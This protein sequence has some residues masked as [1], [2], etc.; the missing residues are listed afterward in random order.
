[1]WSIENLR[2]LLEPA[3]G[4]KIRSDTQFS[5]R[6]PVHDDAHASLSVTWTDDGHG[7]KVLLHCHGCGASGKDLAGALGISLGDL[8]DVPLPSRPA[9]KRVGRSPLQRIGGQRRGR[10]G[11]LPKAIV[12]KSA[13]AEVEHTWEQVEVYPYTDA[14]G[15]LVQEVVREECTTC[16]FGRHKQFRQVFINALGRRVKQKPRGFARVLYRMQA[17]IAAVAAGQPIWL[18]EGEKD[19]A[20]AERLGLVATTNAQGGRAFPSECAELF[21][22]ATVRVVLDRDDAGWDRGVDLVSL[23]GGV[24]A[25]VDLLLPGT[26]VAKSD[27]TDHVEAGLWAHDDEFGGLIPV[28]ASEVAAHSIAGMARAKAVLVEKAAA[29]AQARAELADAQENDELEFKRA[30]RWAAEAEIRFEALRDVVDHTRRQAA[31]AGTEWAGTAADEAVAMWRLARSAA[32]LAHDVAKV[33]VPPSLQHEQS[34]EG[35]VVHAD[36]VHAD[37]DDADSG[38]GASPREQGHTGVFEA[39]T[40]A[41]VGEKQSRR[42][43]A[44]SAP[45]FRIVD[46][47]LVEITTNKD[48][49]EQAKLVLGIDARIVEMEYLEAHDDS[50]DVDAPKL[51]G[52]EG[53]LGQKEANPPAPEQLSAVIIGYTHPDSGEFMR[54]RI[55]AIDYRDCGWVESLPG[56]PAYDSKPSGVAKLR[57]AL[58]V[59]GGTITRTVRFRSTGWR[60]DAAGEWFFV[61][62]GGAINAE[63]ARNAP[64]L[65]S[66]PLARY[67]LPA[68]SQ[69]SGRLRHAF[70][71]D[72]AAML[73]TLPTRISSALLGHVYRSALGPNPWVLLLVG[74]PGSYKTSTASIGMHHWGE[75]WDR[76]RPAS[77]MSGN[78]DTLNAL[79]IKLHSAKDALYW[80]DDVAPTRD[81][82][83][84]QKSLEEFARMV[85]N[86]EQRSRSSRDGLSILDGTPP[87]AS[88]I[89]TSEVMPRP[90]SGAQRM[91]AVPL[92]KDEISLEVLTDLDRD[93]SRHGRALLMA[94]FLQYLAANLEQVRVDAFA[95]AA[96]YAKVLRDSGES[97]RQ[98]EAVGEVWGGWVAMTRF[99]LDAGAL[100]QDEVEQILQ[101]VRGGLTDALAAASDPDLPSR[102]GARVRELLAHALRTGLAY[103]DDVRTGQA[104]ES[105]LAG[106]L[107]W[108]RTNVGEYQGIA[109]W[110][111]DARGIRLGYVLSDPGPRDGG[112]AQ[113]LIESTAL[114]QVLKAVAGTMSDAPQIDRGTALRALYDEGILIAEE[115]AGKTPRYT[116]QRTIHCEGRRQR[117][118]SLRLWAVIGDDPDDGY[119]PAVTDDS[120]PDPTGPNDVDADRPAD[121]L[122]RL[123]HSAGRRDS[124]IQ[125][126]TLTE[127]VEEAE[128]VES[129]DA[130][131]HRATLETFM[132]AV[133]CLMCGTP[134]GVGYEGLPI[135]ITCWTRSTAATRSSAVAARANSQAPSIPSTPAEE[136]VQKPVPA[137]VPK[138]TEEPREQPTPGRASAEVQTTQPRKTA[139]TRASFTA[140]AAIV[141]VDGIWLPDGTRRDL[142]EEFSH[143]GHVA[144]LA[145]TLN[146]GTAV[147]D[148]WSEPGQVWITDALARRFGLDPDQL[149]D[150]PR[151]R[152]DEMRKLT[153]GLP[154]V[155]EALAQGWE[156]GGK[157][158]DALGTWTRV[159]RGERRGVWV[160]F[161]SAMSR[162]ELEM[163]VLAD[164]PS[165]A[166]L[167][168]RL[169]LF[170]SALRF[171][172]AMSAASTGF[173]L[174]SS[175]RAKDRKE[176]FAPSDPVPP[177]QMSNTETDL[178]W[179]RNPTEDESECR[180]VHAYDRGGSHAAG[181]AGLGLGI[182]DP[183]HHEQGRA[184]DA[185]L[186]GYWRIEIPEAGD[187]RYPNPLNPRG[188]AFSEPKWVTTPTLQLATEFG[189]SPEVLEAY[190]W[191]RHGRILD[192]WYAHIRD[193]RTAL[194]VDDVHSQVARDQLKVVYTRTLGMLGSSDFMK[195]RAGYAPER[196]HHIIAKARANILRRVNK[197]GQETDR[198]PLAI[199]NDTIVYASNEADP[200][201]AWPGAQ[202]TLGRGFGQYKWEGSSLLA[203]HLEFLTGKGYRGKDHLDLDWNRSGH[204]GGGED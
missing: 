190:V 94:S 144:E 24:G 121:L 96:A 129:S 104:P 41:P 130:E 36:V 65:L 112:E 142:P 187:W 99:L 167:A 47:Q 40:S 88:A 80:A 157:T 75:L 165:P 51:M 176:L 84:A 106:R 82:G 81:W 145:H 110:R 57:D 20:T 101:I 68:P 18:V 37:G 27:F 70:L 202:K 61:H 89:V 33:P 87:R 115:R 76:R 45:M 30:K 50:V 182:G 53:M 148:R 85:H 114:E 49:D 133:P 146:L 79:R 185:K 194:D 162:D 153:G 200:I 35:D 63:G 158:G 97:V 173:D 48:G 5:A 28:T 39:G 8:F 193:A 139:R 136:P 183:E 22:G 19:V 72:S 175:T 168:H 164:D 13:A 199:S 131:G 147:N 77:S 134:A 23:L 2:N 44:I 127:D 141:D 38:A 126:V 186:P 189:Y 25:K 32:R 11:A 21:A 31:E 172:W 7:G 108:R 192:Q 155:T 17:V 15:N 4:M 100:S 125:S 34:P 203:D 29:E 128:A 107:G 123:E 111:D 163:P 103:V 73:T 197:I 179:S 3:G 46:R 59:A 160:A 54:L 102:T 78:G 138:P 195:G 67:D 60:R 55:D 71:T 171:P 86:G 198:W 159:W 58:K 62:A 14:D 116:V 6:C 66:G 83:A 170:A 56:P 124:G 1:M 74:S 154:F 149:G 91:L 43:V 137:P 166:L 105:P 204:T 119:T 196:R 177:A 132:G 151:K 93:E 188:L 98:A 143:V 174:M 150:D 52:R 180:F 201:A 69:E 26:V 42:G 169:S 161:I 12:Q 140:T 113:L 10:L 90:G 184:F 181:I 191:H 156:L 64:V 122:G 9:G 152:A 135:H 120:S 117:L 95:E 92:Q 118:T 178:D 16:E 109:K